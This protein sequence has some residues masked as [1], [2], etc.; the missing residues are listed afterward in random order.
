MSALA[1]TSDFADRRAQRAIRQ[2]GLFRRCST[3]SC[4]GGSAGRSKTSPFISASPAGTSPTKSS[5]G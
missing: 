1:H 5:A 3:A 2:P 4:N